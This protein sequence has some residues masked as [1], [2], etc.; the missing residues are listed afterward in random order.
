MW[1]LQAAPHRARTAARLAHALFAG[2]ALGLGGAW[3]GEAGG[4]G[5][6]V[7]GG[8]R[9]QRVRLHCRREPGPRWRRCGCHNRHRRRWRRGRRLQR[10]RL[11][12][13]GAVGLVAPGAA[14]RAADGRDGPAAVQPARCRLCSA[15]HGASQAATRRV[16]VAEGEAPAAPGR[17]RLACDLHPFALA[18]TLT[19]RSARRTRHGGVRV[20]RCCQRRTHRCPSSARCQRCA[21]ARRRRWTRCCWRRRSPRTAARCRRWRAAASASCTSLGRCRSSAAWLRQRGARGRPRAVAMCLLLFECPR[22]VAVHCGVLRETAT[23]C[24]RHRRAASHDDK[25]YR[26]SRG[27]MPRCA[28]SRRSS[29]DLCR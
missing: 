27:G 24:T 7:G 6:P 29:S 14:P 18:P 12:A 16:A 11:C 26:Y 25:H 19:F 21:A 23:T 15:T 28:T 22:R 13:P 20:S 17:V 3:H 10:C 4:V 2:D 9:R 1:L 5:A 8:C